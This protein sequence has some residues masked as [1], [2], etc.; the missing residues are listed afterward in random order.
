MSS[1]VDSAG[2]EL[3]IICGPTAAGK[4]AIA[5]SLAR[6]HGLAIVSADSRQI[7]RGFDVGTAKPSAADRAQVP[8]YGLDVADPSERWSA[9]RFAND[10]TAWMA[11]ADVERTL[12]VGGTGFYLRALTNPLH[13]APSLDPDAREQLDAELARMRTDELRRWVRT[14]DPPRASL[15]RAQLLRAAEVALLSGRRLSEY[16][17][18]T[19][20]AAPRRARWLVVDPGSRLHGQIE[21]RLDAM[22]AA[23][24]ADEVRALERTV[25]ADA[26]AWQACGYDAIRAL[27]RGALEPAAARDAI[28]IATRQY[29][30]R[31]RTWFRHQVGH[32]RVTR[33]DP[34]DPSCEETVERWWRG[35]GNE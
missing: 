4:S 14:L 31:Q 5:M 6:R 26:P 33:V 16:H 24:W 18:E 25:A 11:K 34:H 8:H 35:G 29:A 12:V 27:L 2:A 9:A 19:A 23:G 22:L 1:S 3:R 32:E 30:K 21:G 13:L 7:Y 28:L 15:G 17:S 10:A 20:P